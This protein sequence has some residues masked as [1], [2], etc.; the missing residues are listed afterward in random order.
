MGVGTI[1]V[2]HA[3]DMV[4]QARGPSVS[5]NW[6]L[7]VI[8][9]CFLLHCLGSCAQVDAIGAKEVVVCQVVG[10]STYGSHHGLD[11]CRYGTGG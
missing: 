10:L 7:H 6:E 9:G 5:S 2:A 8:P 4:G 3:L 1:G 11:E